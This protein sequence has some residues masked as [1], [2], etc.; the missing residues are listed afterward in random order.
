[1]P[2]KKY[3]TYTS[4]LPIEVMESITEFAKQK[5][6]SKNKIIESALKSFLE[7]EKRKDYEEGFKRVAQDTE[8]NEIAEEGMG[9]YAA[10]I[11]NY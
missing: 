4:T 5:K 1:M 2:A 3:V 7:E 6:L 8:M 9:G 11:K 10:Q